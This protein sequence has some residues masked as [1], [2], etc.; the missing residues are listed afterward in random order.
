M[1]SRRRRL[2]CLNSRRTVP[3]HG[4]DYFVRHFRL[5]QLDDIGRRQS[6]GRIGRLHEGHHHFLAHALLRKYDD[7]IRGLGKDTACKHHDCYRNGRSEFPH[8][9]HSSRRPHCSSTYS[10]PLTAKSH[11]NSPRKT[12]KATTKSTEST[13]TTRKGQG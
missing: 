13:E 2:R 3:Q 1:S 11:P 5:F 12:T 8:G 7:I 6:E 9:L 4:D 10:T